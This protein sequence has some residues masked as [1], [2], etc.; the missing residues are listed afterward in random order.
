MV[1]L[2]VTSLEKGTGKTAVCA[3]LGK[4]LL[5]DGKKIGFFKPVIADNQNPLTEGLDGDAAFIK[6]IFRFATFYG[7]KI[8]IPL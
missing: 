3:G 5:S 1:A 6:H 2:Y 4:K 7:N 8:I